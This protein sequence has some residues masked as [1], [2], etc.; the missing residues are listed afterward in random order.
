VDGNKGQT[1]RRRRKTPLYKKFYVIG[2]L[3][4][5]PH[6]QTMLRIVILPQ[7]LRISAQYNH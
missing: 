6:K 3:T 5:I 2:P 7:L 1:I 4:P